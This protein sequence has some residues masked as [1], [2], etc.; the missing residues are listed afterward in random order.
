MPGLKL[1]DDDSCWHCCNE[2][3]AVLHMLYDCDMVKDL[4]CEFISLIND[5]FNISLT[6][7]QALCLLGI[8]P[9]EYQMSGL[10]ELWCQ[11]ADAELL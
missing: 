9:C 11:L 6:K 7:S 3:G 4:W 2:T 1:T 10:K 8:I 5:L